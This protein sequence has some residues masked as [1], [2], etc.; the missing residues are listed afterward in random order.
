MKLW[1]IPI[2][3]KPAEV[4]VN[5]DRM[6]VY[7][8]LTSFADNGPAGGPK[9]LA[10]EGPGKLIVEFRTTITGL[11]GGRKTHRTVERVTLSEPSG[12]LMDTSAVRML[13]NAGWPEAS[14]ISTASFG[15]PRKTPAC[16]KSKPT[17]LSKPRAE[18]PR[19]K[20]L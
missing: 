13:I 19:S 4:H 1:I 7:K 20:R 10:R 11:L 17:R 6:R 18:T 8:W 9:V 14:L 12:V 15:S 16:H 2:K 5:A 3:M